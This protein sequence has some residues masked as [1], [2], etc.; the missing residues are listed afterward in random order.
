MKIEE[1][2]FLIDGRK[3]AM[4]TM[5][6]HSNACLSWRKVGRLFPS[7]QPHCTHGGSGCFLCDISPWL[8]L[9]KSNK[10]LLS[11][12]YIHLTI[13]LYTVRVR[14]MVRSRVE[15]ISLFYA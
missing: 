8:R 6:R 9:L 4:M 13:W 14:L 10:N 5:R 1:D 2:E 12:T 15:L 3:S 7:S 11:D